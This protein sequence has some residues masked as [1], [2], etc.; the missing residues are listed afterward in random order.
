MQVQD[1]SIVCEIVGVGVI[2]S[3]E[4]EGEKSD[5]WGCKMRRTRGGGQLSRIMGA[6]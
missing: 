1:Y 3:G 4:G 2:E 5:V 6:Q